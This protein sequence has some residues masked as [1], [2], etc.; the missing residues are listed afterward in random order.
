M[1]ILAIFIVGASVPLATVSQWWTGYAFTPG[2]FVVFIG[3]FVILGLLALWLA[4]AF[5]R[6]ILE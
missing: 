6:N 4:V 1:L 5:L 3:P 2:Q